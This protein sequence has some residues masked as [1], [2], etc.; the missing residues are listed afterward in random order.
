MIKKVRKNL[1]EFYLKN[2]ELTCKLGIF[3][4]I[5]N[6][7]LCLSINTY[8]LSEKYS[9]LIEI[10]SAIVFA[11]NFFKIPLL[12]TS[13]VRLLMFSCDAICFDNMPV[14]MHASISDS[15]FVSECIGFGSSTVAM[16]HW[17]QCLRL[18]N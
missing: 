13:T 3:I 9:F 11:L 5:S 14:W 12:K 7:Y 10:T 2:I 17:N 6:R 1:I 18:S 15:R 4:S 8:C 16:K